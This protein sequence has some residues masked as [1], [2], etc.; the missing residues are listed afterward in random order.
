MSPF[1]EDEQVVAVHGRLC[2]VLPEEA[3]DDVEM[4]AAHARHVVRRV[5]AY[6]APDDVAARTFTTS[7]AA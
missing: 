1:L 3:R 7:P 2:A 5:A 6:A 4:D